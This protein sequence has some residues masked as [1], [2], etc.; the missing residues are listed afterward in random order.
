VEEEL[1]GRG[2]LWRLEGELWQ[3]EGSDTANHMV[4]GLRLVDS[5]VDFNHSEV[6]PAFNTKSWIRENFRRIL[7]TLSIFS[8][9]H[10]A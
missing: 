4:E 7:I 2:R 5:L 3:L 8:F 10:R 1:G 9:I 6:K